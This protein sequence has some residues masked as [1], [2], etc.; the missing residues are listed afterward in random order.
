MVSEFDAK[1]KQDMLMKQSRNSKEAFGFDLKEQIL[2]YW[3][4][5][6]SRL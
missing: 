2:C 3:N 1:R 5:T 6:N 4:S